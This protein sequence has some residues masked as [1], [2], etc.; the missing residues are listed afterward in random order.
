MCKKNNVWKIFSK[1]HYGQGQIIT[2][3]LITLLY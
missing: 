3:N 2:Y 1:E